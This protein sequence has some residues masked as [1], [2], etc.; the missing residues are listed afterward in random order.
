MRRESFLAKIINESIVLS[1][2]KDL[3]GDYGQI[4]V[5]RNI[6]RLMQA[7]KKSLRSVVTKKSSPK[8]SETAQDVEVSKLAASLSMDVNEPH[9]A[10]SRMHRC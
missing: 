10:R 6:S 7:R 5:L 4:D 2:R 1:V 9:D 3:Q 8:A